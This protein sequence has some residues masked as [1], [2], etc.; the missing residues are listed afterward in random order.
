MYPLPTALSMWVK[1]TDQQLEHRWDNL[2]HTYMYLISAPYIGYY[3][4][5][6]PPLTQICQCPPQAFGNITS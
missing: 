1:Y 2:V 4:R 6:V 5:T 3:H